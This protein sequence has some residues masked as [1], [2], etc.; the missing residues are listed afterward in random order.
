MRDN[1]PAA[2]I[3]LLAKRVG[4]RCSNPGCRRPT[5]GPRTDSAKVVNI[6]VAAH[7]TA[8]A[9]GG[10]RY[11]AKLS[12]AERSHLNN[13]IWLCQNCAKLIDNDPQHFYVELLREWKSR[14]E[15]Q[16]LAALSGEP[17]AE[18]DIAAGAEAS[19]RWQKISITG[20]HHDYRL[21]LKV[22]N[23]SL[24]PLSEFHIDLT[25]PTEVLTAAEQHP[26]FVPGRSDRQSSFFRYV[27]SAKN[28]P[29]YPGD[30]VVLIALDYHMNNQIYARHHTLFHFNVSASLYCGAQ[31]PVLVE[32]SFG[33]I[34]CF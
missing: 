12:E 9:V 3:E 13:G 4:V 7:I 28:S 5:S 31:S 16:A 10:P 27:A 1:F 19:I 17:S 8:A 24:K 32:L 29:I 6:G 14:S 20:E 26:L 33:E 30:E 2:A 34:Q 15:T 22:A 23:R 25:F 11:D 18:R 21:E